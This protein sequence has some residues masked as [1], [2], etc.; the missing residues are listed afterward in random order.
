MDRAVLTAPTRSMNIPMMIASVSFAV[1]RPMAAGVLT[2]RQA[3]TVTD[4]ATTSAFGAAQL[5][6][7]VVVHT[8]LIGLTRG[9]VISWLRCLKLCKFE[10]I[11]SELRVRL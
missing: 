2:I 9:K 1:R 6:L 5:L 10:G 4:T 8:V 3:N 7:G 11:I